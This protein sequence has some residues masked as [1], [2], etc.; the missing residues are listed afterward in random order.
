MDFK[1]VI[2]CLKSVTMGASSWRD[3]VKQTRKLMEANLVVKVA[4]HF[5]KK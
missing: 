3:I 2:D 4:Y 5:Q 1:V